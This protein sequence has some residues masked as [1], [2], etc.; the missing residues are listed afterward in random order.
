[1][2]EDFNPSNRQYEGKHFNTLVIPLSGT[3]R[4]CNVLLPVY[5]STPTFGACELISF[6]YFWGRIFLKKLF[7]IIEFSF[8][9]IHY[10][11][12]KNLS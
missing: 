9:Y 2:N 1:M 10:G 4:Q 7:F 8:R 5:K 11:Y 3:Q 12:M 6:S